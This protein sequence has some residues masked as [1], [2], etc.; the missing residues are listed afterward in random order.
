MSEANGASGRSGLIHRYRHHHTY[1]GSTEGMQQQQATATS[2][3]MTVYIATPETAIHHTVGV[4]V[5]T[6]ESLLSATERVA[7]YIYEDLRALTSKTGMSLTQVVEAPPVST[8]DPNLFHRLL[9]MDIEHLLSD[10]HTTDIALLL[11]NP[12][13]NSDGRIWLR[14]R[15]SYHVVRVVDWARS[16]DESSDSTAN[17]PEQSRIMR[18]GDRFD[19]QCYAITAEPEVRFAVAVK[20]NPHTAATREIGMRYPHYHFHWS[21]VGSI[22]FDD[23]S[24]VAVPPHPV[25]TSGTS[26]G[27]GPLP[28]LS[29]SESQAAGLTPQMDGIWTL[30]TIQHKVPSAYRP[31]PVNKPRWSGK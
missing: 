29:Q 18:Y 12:A 28:L 9:C 25:A 8:N 27:T 31:R 1:G 4:E 23:E 16:V 19:P 21:P 10:R 24:R 22:V 6:A 26:S 14:Y 30:N 7:A 11:A 20:W 5:M 13:P 2:G 15:S 17:T 3:S